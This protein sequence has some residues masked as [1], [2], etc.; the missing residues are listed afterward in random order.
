MEEA[1]E[2]ESRSRDLPTANRSLRNQPNDNK[3]RNWDLRLE[4]DQSNQGGQN[5]SRVQFGEERVDHR[6]RNSALN[7][8]EAPINPKVCLNR[9]A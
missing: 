2:N 4:S 9:N 8:T 7:N 1:S 6:F 3:T 5:A